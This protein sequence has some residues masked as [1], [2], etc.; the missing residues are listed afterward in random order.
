MMSRPTQSR[1]CDA[2]ET[3]KQEIGDCNMI[4]NIRG[5]MS[6]ISNVS[7]IVGFLSL[8]IGKMLNVAPL[9]CLG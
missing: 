7:T 2:N 9:D 3:W 6:M 4:A 1:G 8:I 5:G